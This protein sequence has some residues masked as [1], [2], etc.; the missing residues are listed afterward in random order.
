MVNPFR[1]VCSRTEEG[2]GIGMKLGIY[3]SIN[4]VNGGERLHIIFMGNA[5]SPSSF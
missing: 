2:N 1:N 5:F 4:V 3:V